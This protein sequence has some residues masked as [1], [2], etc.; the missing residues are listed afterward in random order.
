MSAIET[1]QTTPKSSTTPQE[2]QSESTSNAPS[3]SVNPEDEW[4]EDAGDDDGPIR[5][6]DR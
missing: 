2:T 4:E 5:L 1:V 3:R 6:N